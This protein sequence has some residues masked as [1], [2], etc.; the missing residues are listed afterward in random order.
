MATLGISL[1]AY[2]AALPEPAS[3]S[4]GS[5]SATAAAVGLHLTGKLIGLLPLPAAECATGQ[6]EL[7]HPNGTP[8]GYVQTV[9]LTWN[10][11]LS[12]SSV[13]KDR[14]PSS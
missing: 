9:G 2:G 6:K 8:H 13:A 12:A 7:F 11:S 14:G 3:G 5:P 4:S 1:V 10:V